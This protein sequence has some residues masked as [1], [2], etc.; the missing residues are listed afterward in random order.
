MSSP[1]PLRVVCFSDTHS[2]HEAVQVPPGDVLIFAGDC[3][4][5]GTLAELGFFAEWWRALPHPHK[6]L[7]A[8]NH[9]WPFELTSRLAQDTL[10]PETHYLEDRMVTVA[11]L[12]IYGSP[13]TPAFQ[14]WAFNLPRTNGSLEQ[15]WGNIPERLD[16]L[17]THGS[18]FMTVDGLYDDA[19]RQA[20]AWLGDRALRRAINAVSP[21][22]HICGHIHDGARHARCNGTMIHNVAVLDG[23]YNHARDPLV[24]HITPNGDVS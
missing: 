11:G 8:G 9:D 24:L 5:H 14:G 3:C 21:R 15:R 17:V 1:T 6:I 13:W 12:R 20:T 18:P 2:K 23:E 16:V 10:G 7:V 22:Y 4:N 19:G